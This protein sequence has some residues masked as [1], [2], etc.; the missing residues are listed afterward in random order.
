MTAETY[1]SLLRRGARTLKEA[2]VDEPAREA[3][4]L[5]ALAAHMRA[6]DLI[7]RERDQISDAGVCTRFEAFI[8]RRSLREPFAHIAGYRQFYGLALKADARALV[9]R[10]DSE[11]AV[12][13]AL[14]LL[15]RGR[16]V[17][18]AD[19]GTGSGCLLAA[20]LCQRSGVRGIAIEAKADAG[21]LAREN[22]QR[23]NILDRLHL[24]IGSWANWQLWSGASLVISNP[25]YIRSA[26]IEQLDPEVREHDPRFA[27]DGG[28]DGLDAYREIISL[29]VQ[30]LRPATPLVLEIGFDQAESVCS[31]L[32]HA[33]FDEISVL[34]DF[35]G[36]D[37]VVSGRS[38][39]A[40]S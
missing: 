20:I 7:S 32:Q 35:S 38:P 25:P 34:K 6:V 27:L 36:H 8:R 5:L 18:V 3:R 26:E 4:L 1:L 33:G 23:L 24:T 11:I 37:R 12:E 30:N 19:L 28:D 39:S 15:P 29:G 17:T 9:P 2:G 16:G 13:R 22:F 21:A 40:K 14:E 10:H 31:I